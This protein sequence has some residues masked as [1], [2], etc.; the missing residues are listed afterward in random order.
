M[1]KTNF[2]AKAEELLAKGDKCLK[3]KLIHIFFKA[4]IS[5]LYNLLL[6]SFFKNLSSTK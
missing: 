6:G 3:G 2:S 1:D 5:N 4:L